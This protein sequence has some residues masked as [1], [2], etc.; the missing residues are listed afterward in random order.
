MK[1]SNSSLVEVRQLRSS[2]SAIR[3]AQAKLSTPIDLQASPRAL[4]ARIELC[5]RLLR[6]IANVQTSLSVNLQYTS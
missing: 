5:Q 1:I 6:E 2:L 3:K 4:A